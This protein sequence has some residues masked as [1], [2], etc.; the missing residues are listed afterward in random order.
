MFAAAAAFADRHP[1]EQRR[2]NRD[3]MLHKMSD[4]AWDK[5]IAV[6]LTGAFYCLPGGAADARARLRAIVNIASMSW[7]ATSARQTMPLPSGIV[8]LTKTAARELAKKGVT[9]NAIC[10][11]FIDTR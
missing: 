3:G 7:L 10:P 6:N 8:G 11:G 2:I 5:V 9:V 4:E 1:G